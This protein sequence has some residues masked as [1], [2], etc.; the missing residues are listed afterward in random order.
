MK[1]VF[2]LVVI[3]LLATAGPAAAAQGYDPALWSGL[4]YREVGPWR[5]GRVT[6]VTG[7]PSQPRTFYMGTVGGGVWKT[8]DAGHRWTNTS[9]GQISVGSIGAVAVADSNPD[10]VYAGTGSSKIRSNVS[11]GR[12]LYKSVDAAKTWRFM[13]LRDVGQIA[14]VRVNPTDPNEVFVAATGDPFKYSTERGVYR[15]RD[16]GVTWKKIFFLNE[17]LGAADIEFQADNP[18]ILYATM[19]HGLR[20]P[21]SII[22]GGT[23]GGVY[24]SVDGGDHWVKLGGGLPT[25]LF[26][27][28]NIG[29][30]ASAPNVLYAL[31]EAKPGHGLYRSDDAGATW[32]LVNGEARLVTRPF[33]YTTLG[34]DP[35]DANVVFVGNEGWFKSVDGGKTFKTRPVP[36]GDNHD[37][38]MNPKDSRIMVQANDGGAN[39]SVDGGD[40]WTTQANQPTAEIYQVAVDNQFPYRLY[41]A[42]QDNTTVIVPSLS[43]GDGQ[44]YRIG[45]GC[46]TGPIIPKIDDPNLVWGAC[47]GQFSRLDLRTNG[48]EQRYWIGSES[49]YGND[50]KDLRYRFQRVAPLEVSPTR[51]ATIYYGS[52]FVHRSPDGGVTW[53]T[54]SPDL[55]ANP[56]ERQFASGE[57][58]T[59]D[60][61][62]EEIYSTVYAIRESG[63]RPG[64][65]WAGSN[66][67]LVHVTQ[68][69]G[70]T[71]RNVT[72]KGLPP[73]GRVQNIEP[74]V[75]APGTAY[76][77]I[78]RYLMGDFAPYLYATDNYGK[79]WKRLADGRNGIAA[80]EPTRVIREDP[81]RPGLLYAG[82]EFGMYASFD[83][84]AHWQSLQLDLPATP[85]TDIRLA[86]G[87]LILSTQGRG[88]WILDNLSVLRQVP[89]SGAATADRLYAPVTAVRVNSTGDKGSDPAEGPEYI[90]PGAQID[91]FIGP[92][93]GGKPVSIAFVD[94]TGRTV[95][96]FSSDGPAE[97]PAG[98]G[99]GGDEDG[100]G[101]YRP[102]YPK[103]PATTPGMHR[104]IWDLRH[105]G[106]P[107]TASPVAAT[108]AP[109]P[110][111]T[112]A[113]A[114]PRPRFPDGPMVPPGDYT[115][116]L[117]VGG[118]A[119]RQP[120]RIVEDPRVVAS[121]VTD[122]DLVAQY[123][124][125]LRV[126][127][128]V[129]DTGR[130][131]ARVTQAQSAQADPARAKALKPIADALITPRIRYSK[132]ALQTHV[133]YLYS[134]TGSTD[135]KVGADAIGRYA[136]LRQKVDA[137]V[138]DLDRL[139]GPV[140]LIALRPYLSGSQDARTSVDDDTDDDN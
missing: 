93:S 98:G 133:N 59:R 121:G 20:Q 7:V 48:N 91:Y 37:V 82:T 52:Q 124:H 115:V 45:P 6:T 19:W 26:G 99:G 70:K 139:L 105:T 71:W 88:F 12:G 116:V 39:V 51:A 34:V 101:R 109:T 134:Q 122:A 123:Q 107:G 53:Q 78:Y 86:H 81:E 113:P 114:T 126:L 79:S 2:A 108:S 97:G 40:N 104:F 74:G 57:P 4:H 61:T 110:T 23:E 16:G 17:R 83:S 94:A 76:V 55:T 27:R 3:G 102:V 42:Q 14:T 11:I 58:I 132:P 15:T 130:A 75:R 56:A 128:L 1:S 135:Q 64:V 117:T 28:A 47:K 125:N 62:G 32:R 87:D 100:G 46:E 136:E 127:E 49:L 44:D 29:V 131:V 69:D 129:N 63:V 140:D 119:T 95:R 106:E 33:Y 68:D 92:N 60:A 118:V 38:W 103:T 43:L 90:L 72:P 84:G 25:G 89:R 8:T 73:G 112:A 35:T 50:P 36:H 85:V 80:N 111:P 31:I 5:G 67:G 13:E 10:I 137:I 9:D 18:R 120:L 77:A 24:K 41:G 96:S 30:S 138:A 54:I 66:D 65:I 22:S 21:W